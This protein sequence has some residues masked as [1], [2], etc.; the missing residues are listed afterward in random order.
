MASNVVR[1]ASGAITGYYGAGGQ[2]VDIAT[3]RQQSA[4]PQQQ[5]PLPVIQQQQTQN[6]TLTPV[7]FSHDAGGNVVTKEATQLPKPFVSSVPS[8]PIR[9]AEQAEAA[10]NRG[11]IP[12]PFTSA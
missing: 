8:T 7:T 1:D 9:S 10:M 12:K 4:Q 5:A 6:P 3:V 11:D 2:F